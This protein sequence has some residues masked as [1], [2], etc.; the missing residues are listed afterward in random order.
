MARALEPRRAALRNLNDQVG[1]W[2]NPYKFP[3]KVDRMNLYHALIC[4]R[5]E[6]RAMGLYNLTFVCSHHSFYNDPMFS[7]EEWMTMAHPDK[8]IWLNF[9][10]HEIAPE[11][12]GGQLWLYDTLDVIWPRLIW[13]IVC[14]IHHSDDEDE[15]EDEPENDNGDNGQNQNVFRIAR[16]AL[17]HLMA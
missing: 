17:Q 8:A 11:D 13:G 4:W 9:C 10:P 12:L 15:D 3:L 14:P 5:R 6:Y 16:I 1:F 2:V 7:P